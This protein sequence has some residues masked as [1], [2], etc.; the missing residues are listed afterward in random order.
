MTK[1]K[2]PKSN[3]LHRAWGSSVALMSFKRKA[4][5]IALILLLGAIGIILGLINLSEEW[6]GP[7]RAQVAIDL[8]PAALPKYTM[9]SLCRGLIAYGFSLLFTLVYGYWAAKDKIAERLLIPLL[10]I[11]QSIPV[12]GFMPGLI[13]ALVALFPRS[14]I[15]L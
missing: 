8:S 14:N 10:D 4:D 12:L 2:H 9:Y 13:L 11:L 15:G 3:F 5:W 6:T 7:M 1:L